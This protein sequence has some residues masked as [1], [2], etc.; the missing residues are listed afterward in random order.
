MA[1]EMLEEGTE[2]SEKVDVYSYG[3]LLY[4]IF[5]RHLPYYEIEKRFEVV[6][7]VLEGYRP[8]FSEEEIPYKSLRTLMQSCWNKSPKKRPTFSAILEKLNQSSAKVMKQAREESSV[9]M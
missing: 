5:T 7:R 8:T 3:I 2:Y 4:E 6:P 1:P 9:T